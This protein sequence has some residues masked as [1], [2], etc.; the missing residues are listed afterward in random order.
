MQSRVRWVK[1]HVIISQGTAQ[2]FRF[3]CA[4]SYATLEAG[5]LL[6]GTVTQS[7]WQRGQCVSVGGV[8]VFFNILT[9]TP[10]FP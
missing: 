6:I 10:Q 3:D 8:E 9:H 7:V 5:C 4:Q 2:G 1:R